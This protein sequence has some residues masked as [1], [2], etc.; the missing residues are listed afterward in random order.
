MRDVVIP[1]FPVKDRDNLYTL[2]K[3]WRLPYWDWA[4]RREDVTDP[5]LA[6]DYN[7]PWIIRLETVPVLTPFG[8]WPIPNP[9]YTFKTPEKMGT[10]G[11]TLS[12]VNILYHA[13]KEGLMGGSV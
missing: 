13:S 5:S 2:A 9:L 1:Y 12:P 7:V 11:I 3:S 8:V 10:Y 6:E 4:A